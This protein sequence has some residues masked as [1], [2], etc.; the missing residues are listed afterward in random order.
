MKRKSPIISKHL[1]GSLQIL[2][3]KEPKTLHLKNKTKTTNE[4]PPNRD[5]VRGGGSCQ[6]RNTR[7]SE[8]RRQ[9]GKWKAGEWRMAVTRQG[10]PRR[11]N[12][13]RR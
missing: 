6:T 13:T 1:Q 5:P 11:V 10:G 8:N 12:A 3:N 9:T 4:K 2:T 7:A